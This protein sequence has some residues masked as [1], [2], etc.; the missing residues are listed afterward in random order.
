MVVFRDTAGKQRK[1]AARTLAEARELKAALTTDVKR[2]EYRALSRVTFAEYARDWVESY[3]VGR[4]R[5]PP[6][7]TG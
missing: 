2:G 1:R 7:D 5:D 4:P 3:R 6:R